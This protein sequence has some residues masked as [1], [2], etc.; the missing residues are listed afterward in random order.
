MKLIL[1]LS[2]TI[3]ILAIVINK[4]HLSK[5]KNQ[6]NTSF[7]YVKAIYSL[8]VTYDPI[9]MNDGPSLGFSELVYEGLLRFSDDYGLMPGLAKSW[10]TS[11][12]GTVITFKLNPE[13]KF[14]NG[15]EVNAH[16]VK[17]SLSRNVSKESLVYKYYEVI[18][19]AKEYFKFI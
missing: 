12:D 3:L 18:K 6:Q 16:D 2:F 1:G 13:A 15:E 11:A 14:Q 8:P 9:K 5:I 7:T 17:A 4:Q 10:S 19:G